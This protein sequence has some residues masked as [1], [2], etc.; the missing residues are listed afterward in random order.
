ML[1]TIGEIQGQEVPVLVV[2]QNAFAE[3]RIAHRGYVMQGVEIVLQGSTEWLQQAEM[4]VEAYLWLQHCRET[5]TCRSKVC[6]ESPT[7]VSS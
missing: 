5:Q 3:V 6:H 7:S 1:D 4:V 2:E